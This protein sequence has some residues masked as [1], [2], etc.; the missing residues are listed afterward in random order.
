MYLTVARECTSDG[1]KFVHITFR[2]EQRVL[3]LILT[4]RGEWE[5][6]PGGPHTGKVN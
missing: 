1:R 3:S 2:D 4:R 6:L 5:K